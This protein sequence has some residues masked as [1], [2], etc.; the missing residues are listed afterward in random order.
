MRCL[1]FLIF[2]VTNSFLLFSQIDN[3]EFN[4]D[5]IT[6][7]FFDTDS[8][9]FNDYFEDQKLID[10]ISKNYSNWHNRAK[11]IEK[12]QIDKYNLNIGIDNRNR[13]L[14]LRNGEKVVLSPNPLNEEAGFAFE[15]LIL[16]GI[17]H[18]YRVQ[19]SEGN[20]YV[21][22][23]TI[24]G[25]K[26]YTYGRVFV[27]SSHNYLVSI[28]DDIEAGYSMNGI[29]LFHIDKDYNLIELWSYRTEWAPRKIKWNSE[30][31]LVLSGYYY[32]ESDGWK[33]KIFYKK[34]KIT[35]D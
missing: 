6:I 7:K 25:K 22:V 35:Y 9:S 23:N 2:F 10:S 31:E 19:W 21:L 8:V 14:I 24:T 18:L 32:D 26:T 34:I 3:P 11:A 30:N 33:Y 5:S 17:F 4:L 29:Q 15:K 13:T 20:N 27:N 28:N 16:N 1:Y 12:Y